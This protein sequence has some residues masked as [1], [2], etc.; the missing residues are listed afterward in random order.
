MSFGFGH[1]FGFTR[2]GG[3]GAAPA[4][5]LPASR[6]LDGLYHRPELGFSSLAPLTP[7]RDNGTDKAALWIDTSQGVDVEADG[8]AR[9]FSGLGADELASFGSWTVETGSGISGSNGTVTMTSATTGAQVSAGIATGWTKIDVGVSSL[10]GSVIIKDG[11]TTIATIS[12]NGDTEYAA[13]LGTDLRVEASGTTS[14]TVTITAKPIPGI[15]GVQATANDQP[16]YDFTAGALDLPGTSENLD[17]PNTALSSD[18]TAFILVKIPASDV[19]GI[20]LGGTSVFTFV[21]RDGSA[22]APTSGSGLPTIPAFT[23][24]GAS[25]SWASQDAAHAAICT[26]AWTIVGIHGANLT[27]TGWR[28]LILGGYSLGSFFVDGLIG[29][30]VLLDAPSVADQNAALNYLANIPD[31]PI[32]VTEIT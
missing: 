27:A 3:G 25:Q 18:V 4:P 11:S 5:T 20:L 1:G 8:D 23:L 14:A 19:M 15:H 16:P 2:T 12:A 32:T 28:G 31:T 7:L 17:Y 10:S 24:N 30:L 9:T 13:R 21:Y 6:L 29:G 22:T 26:D